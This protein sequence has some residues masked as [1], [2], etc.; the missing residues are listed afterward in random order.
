[1]NLNPFE[2]PQ[3]N[4]EQGTPVFEGPTNTFAARIIA[5]VA[6]CF[7]APAY[8]YIA[9][10]DES[11]RFLPPEYAKLEDGV[12]VAILFWIV[13]AGVIAFRE[14]TR[15]FAH[16]IQSSTIPPRCV[17]F[18]ELAYVRQVIDSPPTIYLVK[19]DGTEVVIRGGIEEFL[20]AFEEIAARFPP[21]A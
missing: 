3:H 1:M 7:V 12:Y 5:I 19:Q 2:S 8:V 11:N 6:F 15:V 21:P 10:V 18:H 4:E 17:R 16:S 9:W 13:V 14:R 20:P